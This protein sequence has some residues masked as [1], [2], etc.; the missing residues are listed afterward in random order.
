MI[1]YTI[2]MKPLSGYGN[3][4]AHVYKWTTYPANSV[5][6]GQACKAF[7]TTYSTVEEAQAAYPQA[8]VGRR[9]AHNTFNHL[10]GED[11]PVPGGMYLDD[12]EDGI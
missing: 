6:A 9:E 11:D 5:L 7:V 12:Y 2:E 1:D 10:T 8:D 3:A 4:V